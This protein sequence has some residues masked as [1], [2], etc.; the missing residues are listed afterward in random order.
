MDPEIL[1]LG[2]GNVLWADEG[3]GVR[4]VEALNARYR[5]DERVR[6]LDGGTQG[7][8]LLDHVKSAERLLVLD[9]IDFGLTPGTLRVFRDDDVPVWG[10]CKTSMHQVGFQEVLAL[11]QLAGRYPRSLAL[12]GVQPAV[13]ADF[14][15]SLSP[16][17]AAQLE[18]AVAAAAAILAEWGAPGAP[19]TTET[20]E[21]LGPD[22]LQIHAYEA[23]RPPADAACRV[24]DA[25]FL[26]QRYTG[27]DD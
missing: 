6:L 17:V 24:G 7:L 3:F 14:G 4:A 21:P 13:L 5:F 19:R 2:I 10:A 15:G 11:A 25:R 23:G 27:R 12:V 18:P 26:N 8:Y 1:V 16:R 9:A 20:A 22:A